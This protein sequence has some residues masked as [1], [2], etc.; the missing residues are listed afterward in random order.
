MDRLFRRW[1]YVRLCIGA[2][3]IPFTLA[4]EPGPG[5]TMSYADHTLD[6]HLKYV[7]EAT[8]TFCGQVHAD[9]YLAPD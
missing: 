6:Q 7:P 1:D 8:D 4:F 2:V 5:T 9:G 3:H